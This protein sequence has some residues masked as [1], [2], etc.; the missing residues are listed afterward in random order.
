MNA[1]IMAGGEGSRLRPLTCDIPKPMARLCGRPVLE[2][3]LDLLAVNGVTHAAV[4]LK[5]LPDEIKAHFPDGKYRG[6][7]L[8]FVEEDEPL[9]TAGSVK[10]AA[11]G[12]KEP[13]LVISGDAMC[14]YELEK[15]MKYHIAADAQATIL[16]THVED[17]REYGLVRFDREGAVEGFIEKPGWGQAVCN[18][19]NTGIYIL[20]PACLELI[21]DGEAFDFARD[22]FP[23]MLRNKQKV[24]AYQASGYWCDI[25]DIDAYR[26]C[27]ADMLAGKVNCRMPPQVSQGIYCKEG[28]PDGDYSLEPP[29]YIGADVEIGD[30]AVVGSDSVV[31]DGCM[32]APGAKARMSTLLPG[33][34]VGKNASLTGALLCASASCGKGAS[35]YEGSVL[36]AGAR[37]G[38]GA[39]VKPGVYI[40]PGKHIDCAAVVSDHVK[41][42]VQHGSVFGEGGVD[43]ADLSPEACARFGEAVGSASCGK[44]VG[45]ACE[46]NKESRA[47]KLALTAGLMA[48]GSH[49][50]DFGECFESQLMFFTSFCS[51]GAGAFVTGGETP[52]IRL[53]GAGGLPVPRY[54]ER[55]I[56]N[57]FR[58]GDF[59]RCSG[60]CC[61]DVAD[62]SSVKMMYQ[63]ELCR[64]APEGIPN[65]CAQINSENE[66][67]VRLMEDC[68]VRLGGR[69]GG[70]AV[71][72][73]DVSG[74]KLMAVAEN[75]EEI[76][77]EKLLAVCCVEQWKKGGDVSLP[78]DA[79]GYLDDM[80]KGF[81]RTVY[82]FLENPAN[83]DDRYA[84]RMSEK[85]MWVRDALFMAMR[86]MAVME[87][88]GCP[89]EELV[90]RL[91]AFSVYADEV[92]ARVPPSKLYELFDTQETR[93]EACGEG[94]VLRRAGGRVLI[95]PTR[96]GDKFRLRAEAA[97]MET[98]R[99]LCLH[100][101]EVL[102][103]VS[104]DSEADTE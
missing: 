99:E 49:V 1:V 4:T 51:L 100:A 97:E 48:C 24:Y 37:L 92:E 46:P 79:P 43:G 71:F 7:D 69:S 103:C 42:G 80:A 40:W 21:P 55:E 60:D 39:G 63:Q 81:D 18:T 6:I 19:A 15:A 22:L 52:G 96:S 31:D 8:E 84:R 70:G 76:P 87:A 67:I 12:Y 33:A 68:M 53:C 44:R 82:R 95:T 41:Y 94:I 50:W 75:G 16:V 23:M 34:G 58:R 64:Q 32:V 54:A 72:C 5:Y 30:G 78:Y 59:R 9:G 73:I 102:G 88:N 90:S 11:A 62:M 25:G 36:G 98:A 57:R 77:Q 66:Q 65:V 45:V 29:V 93:G 61:R 101:E 2:Y 89:L 28:L 13:F 3:I 47:R 91:P 26:N 10:H 56:E 14:D 83:D 20:E 35:M 27:Q 38:A 104:L 17:P 74:T 86:V 85:Q